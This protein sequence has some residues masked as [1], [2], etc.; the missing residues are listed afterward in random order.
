MTNNLV[1]CKCNWISFEI[2]EEAAKKEREEFMVYYNTLTRDQQ[3]SYYGEDGIVPY[4]E[5]SLESYTGVRIPES[6]DDPIVALLDGLPIENH[7]LLKDR[8][9]VD[10]PDNWV[11]DYLVGERIHGTAMASLILHGELDANEQSLPSK[12]YVRPI[13]R[14]GPIDFKTNR[15]I[16]CIPDNILPTDILYRAVH[17]MFEGEGG[18]VPASAPSVRVINLSIG[19]PA[20]PLDH[21]PSPW[22]RLV[23]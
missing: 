9:V 11:T 17:L 1:K 20:H 12:I 10:D 7:R 2:T 22:A 14:P 18:S 8:L 3:I 19:D 15:R 16:E 21:F 23:D 4:D 5:S 6:Q 13:M